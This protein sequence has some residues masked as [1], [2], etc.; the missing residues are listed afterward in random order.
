L[1]TKLPISE[2]VE[3]RADLEEE[4]ISNV[5]EVQ[6]AWAEL[7]AAWAVASVAADQPSNLY[8]S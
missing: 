4:E 5:S 1:L 2:E 8:F 3:I 6:V 7:Q